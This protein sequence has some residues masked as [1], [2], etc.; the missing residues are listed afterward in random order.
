VTEEFSEKVQEKIIRLLEDPLVEILLEKS[1][2][3]KIQLETF[4]INVL[5]EEIVGRKANFQEKAGCRQINKKISRGAFNRT[6][7]QAERNTTRSINTILL[8]GYLGILDSPRL[9]PFIEVSNRL[10]LYVKTYSKLWE[11]QKIEPIK[12]NKLGEV[13]S[14]RKNLENS[15]KELTSS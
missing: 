8:L 1:H 5:A 12:Q 14:L 3:S 15:L 7:R 10:D 4:L 6:L 11:R 13:L 9:Q 2:L